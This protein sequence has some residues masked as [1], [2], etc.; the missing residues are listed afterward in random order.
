MFQ[1]FQ[2]M[3]QFRKDHRVLRSNVSDGACGLPDIAVRIKCNMENH[4]L[5]Q[6][7]V[8]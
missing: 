1:F 5:G 4:C 6:L 3:I 8:L 2:W 7:L